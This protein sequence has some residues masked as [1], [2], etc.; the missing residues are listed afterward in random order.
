MKIQ[1][2]HVKAFHRMDGNPKDV[3]LKGI[4]RWE[5]FIENE[6]CIEP[7]DSIDF[8]IA[9]C[10]NDADDQDELRAHLDYVIWQLQLFRENIGEGGI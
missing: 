3:I 7:G 6:G 8:S 10:L 9:A 2:K 5:E 4:R 1:D